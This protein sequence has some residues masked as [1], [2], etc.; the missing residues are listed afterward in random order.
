MRLPVA[1]RER[2]LSFPLTPMIDMVFLLIIF[3]LVASHV[4]KAEYAE[5]I[6]LPESAEG[7]DVELNSPNRLTISIDDSYEYFIAGTKVTLAEIDERIK[8]Q[9]PAA[10]E[11]KPLEVRVRADK[12]TPYAQ[13]RPIIIS[14]VEAGG[15]R[16]S[17]GVYQD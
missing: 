11:G 12:Q 10:D 9:A 1:H 2:E 13:L 3:F 6:E 16:F 4:I 15:A 8:T 7:R 5:R 14:C 17:F